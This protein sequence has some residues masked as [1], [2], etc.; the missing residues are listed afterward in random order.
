MDRQRTFRSIVAGLALGSLVACGQPTLEVPPTPGSIA[1]MPGI[2]AVSI[3][4]P[5]DA[6]RV[7][8]QPQPRGEAARQGA[9]A[10]AKG[11]VMAGAALAGVAAEDA[12]LDDPWLL[13][14]APVFL[15]GGLVIAPIAAAAGAIGGAA[16]G[17]SEAELETAEASVTRAL[18]ENAQ[19]ET[20]ALAVV[21][22]TGRRT[23]RTLADCGVASSPSEC[24]LA[25]GGA[26]DVL[27]RLTVGEPLF[28]AEGKAH[29]RL[30]LVRRLDAEILPTELGQP[31][32][33][34][35][36]VYRGTEHRYADM[37]ADDARLLRRELAAAREALIAKAV[38]DLFAPGEPERHIGREQPE[39]GVWTVLPPAQPVRGSLPFSRR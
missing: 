3:Q 8:P 33:K 31:T 16:S 37:A 24:R 34:R 32:H 12:L 9:A 15:V 2:W 7:P 28:L 5:D 29:P 17:M 27:L 20:L 35:S 23:S 13:V 36:W 26:P 39:G 25:D 22:E 11:S 1:A 21:E 6:T 14:L 38:G 4:V 30:R 10:G 19:D 18:A